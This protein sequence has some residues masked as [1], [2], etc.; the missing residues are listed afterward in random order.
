[1]GSPVTLGEAPNGAIADQR[2]L[3][4]INKSG[5]IEFA[6]GEAADAVCVPDSFD[7]YEPRKEIVLPTTLLVRDDM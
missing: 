5:E 6:S 1:M 4:G 7:R 2:L 3:D